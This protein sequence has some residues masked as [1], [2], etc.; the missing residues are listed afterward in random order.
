MTAAEREKF[1]RFWEKGYPEADIAEIFG[2]TRGD[3]RNMRRDLGLKP[4]C[5]KYS[6]PKAAEGAGSGE[7][8]PPSMPAH[9]F[10]TPERDAVVFRTGGRYGDI[11]ELV[12]VIGR[13]HAAILQRWHQLR[14]S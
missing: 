14:A 6:K 5:G 3:V 9:P 11:A 13:P 4:R 10:W 12:A 1:V 7:K 2:C 8:P